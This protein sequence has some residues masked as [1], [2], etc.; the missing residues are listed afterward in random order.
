MSGRAVDLSLSADDEFSDTWPSSLLL[1]R[2]GLLCFS[3]IELTGKPS[4]EPSLLPSFDFTE[5]LVSNLYLFWLAFPLFF[6]LVFLDW[7]SVTK[8]SKIWMIQGRGLPSSADCLI[9]LN[10]MVL[11]IPKPLYFRISSCDED[12]YSHHEGAHFLL[13]SLFG[14][15]SN[16]VV[17]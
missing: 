1:K 15:R 10:S 6:L 14:R 3:G 12:H 11:E 4:L 8:G 7:T 9:W 2:K 16:A 13:C 5:D 17:L